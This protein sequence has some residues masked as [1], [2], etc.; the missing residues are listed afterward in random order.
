MQQVHRRCLSLSL[1]FVFVS[2]FAAGRAVAQSTIE[3]PGERTPYRVELE[4]HL[5]GNVFDPPG[6]GSGAGFG[7]GGRANF[8]IVS[9]G[10]V[11][12]I[13][14]SIAVGLG[15]DF[16]HYQGVGVRPGICTR[17]VQGPANTNVCVE[18]SRTGGSS[19]YLFLPAVMQWNFWLAR[20]WSVFGEPGLTVYW[21]DHGAVGA[22]P[23]FY[24]GGRFHL[25]D[26][27]TLTLRLGY[28]TIS[29]GA[30]VLF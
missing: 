30:S 22:S 6:G 3:R 26:V 5:I 27:V 2:L 24:V 20:R 19:S 11:S 23:A 14:D 28:P 15:A 8:E 25:T 4:P 29:L 10:F 7:I 13:N 1:A 17:F 18:V 12:T 9:N 21:S 16:I